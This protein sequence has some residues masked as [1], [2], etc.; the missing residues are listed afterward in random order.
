MG[1][2]NKGMMFGG[3][4]GAGLMW[5]NT[6]KKGRA[7]RDEIVT[8]AA[9]VYERVKV[10]MQQSEKLQELSEHEYVQRVQDVVEK[11]AIENGL[12]DKVKTVVT[13]L[14]TKEWKRFKRDTEA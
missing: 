1:R 6:T 9:G 7:M 3:L 4:L 14:V 8:H 12:S 11:Y 10:E 13:Q 5:L 2:F